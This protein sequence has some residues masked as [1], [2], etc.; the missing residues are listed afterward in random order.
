M[1][2]RVFAEWTAESIK[3]MR[4][5]LSAPKAIHSTLVTVPIGAN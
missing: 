4:S 5:Q 3:L 1:N 2:E